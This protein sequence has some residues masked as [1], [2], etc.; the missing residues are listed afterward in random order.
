MTVEIT[1]EMVDRAEA[2]LKDEMLTMRSGCVR[3]VARAALEAA[4]NPPP[5]PEIPVSEG[6]IRA[7]ITQT[8]YLCTNAYAGQ[9][10]RATPEEVE[11]I[12]RAM[13]KKRREECGGDEDDSYLNDIITG[14]EPDETP[15]LKL[16]RA[17]AKNYN[18]KKRGKRKD[19]PK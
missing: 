10:I 19:D 16:L 13:E 14:I 6:M 5:E 15:D 12:Y 4:I 18:R 17:L 9:R 7:G 1:D 8:I 2:L 11:A 3:P